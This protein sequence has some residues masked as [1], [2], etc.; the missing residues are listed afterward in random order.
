[1]SCCCRILLDVLRLVGR[2]IFLMLFI[3]LWCRWRCRY[4]IYIPVLLP[5]V[6][7]WY[8][9]V[10]LIFIAYRL[11]HAIRTN[12]YVFYDEVMLVLLLLFC[13][14]SHYDDSVDANSLYIAVMYCSS[15]S[16]HILMSD[17]YSKSELFRREGCS[18]P[19]IDAFWWFILP[20]YNTIHTGIAIGV[21]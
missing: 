6:L 5:V 15:S 21:L 3:L 9:A 13:C 18:V 10:F 7:I 19:I 1:M 11:C 17:L 14:Q 12:Y 4:Y 2:H 20:H 8:Y 16:I